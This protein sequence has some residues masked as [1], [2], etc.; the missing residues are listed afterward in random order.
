VLIGAVKKERKL[1]N[2]KKVEENM[3]FDEA[4]LEM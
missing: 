1:W 4:N 2:E 3:V